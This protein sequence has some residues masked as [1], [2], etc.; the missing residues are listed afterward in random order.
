MMRPIHS[1]EA[2]DGPLRL[3]VPT[4]KEPMRWVFGLASLEIRDGQQIVPGKI[5]P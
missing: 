3:V 5:T 1:L 4:D 2:K